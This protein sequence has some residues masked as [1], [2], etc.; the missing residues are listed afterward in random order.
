[1]KKAFNFLITITSVVAVL[2]I[3]SLPAFAGV[4]CQPPPTHVPEPATLL[5]LGAG[6]GVVTLV[7]RFRKS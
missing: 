2:A 3:S 4:S 7:R 5:L 6:I 1:V